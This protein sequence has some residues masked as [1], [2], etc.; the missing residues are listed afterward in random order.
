MFVNVAKNTNNEFKNIL[1]MLAYYLNGL[2]ELSSIETTPLRITT[3]EDVI[4]DDFLLF[5]ILNGGSA[6]GFSNLGKHAK[7]DDGLLD[8]V[9]IKGVTISNLP[10]LLFKIIQGKERIKCDIAHNKSFTDCSNLSIIC[11]W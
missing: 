4:E 2:K 11:S 3:Y 9:A 6:G 5:L 8:L 7:M 10:E 1:G